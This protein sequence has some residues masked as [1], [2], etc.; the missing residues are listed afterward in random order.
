MIF[1]LETP[2]ALVSQRSTTLVL[3]LSFCKDPPSA[4]QP[5]TPGGRSLETGH[6]NL[7]NTYTK[8]RPTLQTYVPHVNQQD[9]ILIVARDM[10]SQVQTWFMREGREGHC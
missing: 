4:D 1:D 3:S 6:Q 9:M 7:L 5:V 8:D 10:M 2:E